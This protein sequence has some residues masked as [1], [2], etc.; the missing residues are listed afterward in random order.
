ML[1]SDDLAM[2]ALAGTPA[3]RAAAALAAGCDIALYCAGDLAPTA[4]LLRPRR[5]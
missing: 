2:Q 3:E 1:V 4:E 5:R